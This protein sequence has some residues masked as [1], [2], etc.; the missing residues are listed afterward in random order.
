MSCRNTSATRSSKPN[1]TKL[2]FDTQKHQTK[3]CGKNATQV[4]QLCKDRQNYRRIIGEGAI[5]RMAPDLRC[6]IGCEP[7]APS[8]CCD[9]VRGGDSFETQNVAES[10]FGPVAD[11]LSFCPGYA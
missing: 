7:L 5:R 8:R 6:K 4:R 10:N 2:K 3:V 11:D 1:I 9:T